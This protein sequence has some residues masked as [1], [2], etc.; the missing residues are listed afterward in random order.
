MTYRF[1]HIE[2]L[3]EKHTSEQIIANQ[4]R[5]NVLINVIQWL[6][7]KEY[8]FKGNDKKVDSISHGN[9]IEMIKVLAFYN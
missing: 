2:K 6:T 9:F 8:A 4:L 5:I 7:F 1:H 3:I